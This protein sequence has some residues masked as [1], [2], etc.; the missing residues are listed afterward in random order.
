MCFPNSKFEGTFSTY[1]FG[2]QFDI[3][4]SW[5]VNDGIRDIIILKKY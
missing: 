3:T 5:K 1:V 4:Q 2:F